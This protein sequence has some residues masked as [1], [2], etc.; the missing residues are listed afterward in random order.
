MSFQKNARFDHAFAI[1]RFDE[2][3]VGKFGM[4][5]EHITVKEVVWTEEA[6]NREVERLNQ[7]NSGK[8][9]LY[10]WRLTRVERDRGEVLSGDVPSS[11]TQQNAEK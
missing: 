11:P 9:A 6:A 10:F 8:G 2:F 7:L 3:M 1:L 4:S 5:P